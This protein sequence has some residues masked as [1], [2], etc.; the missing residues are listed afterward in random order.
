MRMAALLISMATLVATSASAQVVRG[1][2]LEEGL[3]IPVDGAMVI[4]FDGAGQPVARVLTD[5][6]GRY[7][8]LAASPG[9]HSIRI[10]RIGYES[11]STGTIEVGPDGTTYN[12]DVP[13]RAVELVGLDVSA[14]RRCQVRAEQGQ[15]TARIWEEARKALEA[16]AWTIDQGVYR[17]TLLHYTRDLDANGHR[18]LDESR[19]FMRGRSQAPYVSLPADQLAER[20]FVHTLEDGRASYFAPDATVLL[21]D[22]FL[23]THCMKLTD[24]EEGMVGLELE[25]ISGRRLPEIRGTLWLDR[26]TAQLRRLEFEYINL[27]GSP[28][29]NGEP[30]GEV[31]FGALP[32]GTWIV[33]EWRIRMPLI[34][35]DIDSGRRS[36]MG[37]RDEGGVV[38]RVMDP[39]GSV[40][41]EAST[42]TVV[43]F[44]T[45][46]TGIGAAEGVTVTTATGEQAITAQ[47]GTFLLS[48]LPEGFHNLTLQHPSLDALGL[49]AP[50]TVVAATSGEIAQANAT[51]PSPAQILTQACGGSPRPSRTAILFGFLRDRAGRP[52]SG[53]D[54]R[55]VP[56][57]GRIDDYS[58]PAR[59][60]PDELGTAPLEWTPE[61]LSGRSAIGLTTDDRSI[62]MLC[63]VPTPAQVRILIG[64]RGA[65]VLSQTVTLLEGATIRMVPITLEEGGGA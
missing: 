19:E 10:D 18:V 51:L 12:I 59:A 42:A 45:D 22:A 54:V 23:D 49:T 32:N 47:D 40:L 6:M 8:V 27:R 11:A 17:Y 26:T 28:R 16:A 64:P 5:R 52:I 15:A 60:A 30:G 14:S 33:R 13:V 4:L 57:T 2:V 20:G 56:G 9:R 1:V 29:V 24:E 25:P 61:Q 44:V 7:V 41:L 55:L 46:S 39:G 36:R 58:L 62:F 38:W 21:S 48:G 3:G 35:E 63:D 65:E 34:A 43:G 31:V 37:Y 53:L 50:S